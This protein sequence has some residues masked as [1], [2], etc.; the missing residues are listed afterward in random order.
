MAG[1]T[2]AEIDL[3]ENLAA[4]EGAGG[5][6]S[7]TRL[8]RV[9]YL[10]PN[11]WDD[12]QILQ[13]ALNDAD[14]PQPLSVLE[15][16]SFSNLVLESRHVKLIERDKGTAEITLNY[17]HVLETQYINDQQAIDST[18]LYGRMR[19]TIQQAPSNFY[20]DYSTTPPGEIQIV[21]QHTYPADDHDWKNKTFKQGGQIQATT[22][23]RS[24][25]FGGFYDTTTPDTYASG[26]IACVNS[27][28]WKGQDP[29][30][31]LCTEVAWEIIKAGRYRF[32]FEMQHNV[33]GWDETA[34]FIDSR[35]GRPP[36]GLVKDVGYKKIPYLKGVGLC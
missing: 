2:F 7:L 24:Y 22:P 30:T 6:K 34:V 21:L 4:E 20:P 15:G 31:W 14:V 23:Q 18:T 29:R 36:P 5:F 16:D 3:L 9:K 11:A 27:L 12:Y 32:D 33:F 1:E 25:R 26:I 19:C 17:R 8:C 35:T 10:D 28:T 13:A